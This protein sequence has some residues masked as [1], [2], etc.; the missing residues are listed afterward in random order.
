MADEQ[1]L[2][3]IEVL[4]DTL[5]QMT[6]ASDKSM[7]VA[8]ADETALRPLKTILYGIAQN[9]QGFMAKETLKQQQEVA[10]VTEQVKKTEEA[11]KKETEARDRADN[12]ALKSLGKLEKEAEKTSNNL[13]LVTRIGQQLAGI[14]VD[15]VKQMGENAK[16]FA[17]F[18]QGLTSAGVSIMDG[19]K[20]F[21]ESLT[22]SANKI[23]MKTDEFVKMVSGNSQ[24]LAR[25]SA[26]G[27]NQMNYMTDAMAQ[28][29]TVAGAS[30]EDAAAV[31]DYMS[32]RILKFDTDEQI[33][34][35]NMTIESRIL[36][37]HFRDLSFAT[38]KSVENLVK[39]QE[40]RKKNYLMAMFEKNR[41]ELTNKINAMQ[42][43]EAV[44]EYALTGR[45]T[46]ELMR[47]IGLNPEVGQL[48]SLFDR[49]RNDRSYDK[50]SME[51]Y[52]NMVNP[53]VDRIK[54]NAQ[55]FTQMGPYFANAFN[56]T[57]MQGLEFGKVGTIT[58]KSANKEQLGFVDAMK[59]MEA[60]VS[61]LSNEKLL[62]YSVSLDKF[63]KVTEALA[64]SAEKA[65]KALRWV[66]E[67]FGD[68]AAVTLNAGESAGKAATSYA[69]NVIGSGVGSFIGTKLGVGKPVIQ[70]AAKS[71]GLVNSG[72]QLAGRALPYL[73]TS[74]LGLGSFAA[75]GAL[76][77]ELV[78]NT[79]AGQASTDWLSNKMFALSKW[80][81][82]DKE[83]EQQERLRRAKAELDRQAAENGSSKDNPPELDFSNDAPLS[84]KP[85][86]S[87][88][89]PQPKT[90]EYLGS[91]LGL[92]EKLTNEIESDAFYRK[93][94]QKQANN[95]T[96]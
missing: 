63:Q 37:E 91:I 14:I 52:A 3:D 69:A 57:L 35:R 84:N 34:N 20:G 92:L 86:V 2:R 60:S 90:E 19:G 50:I 49:M 81:N 7:N 85:E 56:E 11:V 31:W 96:E 80:W 38:G 83:K 6:T 55:G 23:G 41:P 95:M 67:E 47:L 89:K 27:V 76:G 64:E 24:A 10:K 70:A 42:M 79:K 4:V 40:A 58:A 51:D 75:G 26:S 33:R 15:S 17:T 61:N 18:A 78:T 66:H 54:A 87:Q 93:A 62:A 59:S 16:K 8:Y 65:A 88:S 74:L 5:R 68:W 73:G 82:S 44:R 43:P 72:L 29:Q 48:M 53:I 22:D 39:E 1:L 32:E 45:Q 77:Y 94:N 25:L 12:N 13:A 36:L 28:Y 9:F 21:R 30:R 46:P 71:P